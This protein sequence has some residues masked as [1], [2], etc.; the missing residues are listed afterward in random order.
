MVERVAYFKTNRELSDSLGQYGR[1]D[2]DFK[3]G[4]FYKFFTDGQGTH[5]YDRNGKEVAVFEYSVEINEGNVVSMLD[6]LLAFSFAKLYF[7]EGMKGISGVGL[8]D[9]D[10]PEEEL[11]KVISPYREFIELEDVKEFKEKS[12]LG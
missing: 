1:F 9:F 12:G 3:L 2:R 11:G 4:D 7:E 6:I 5:V 8:V 10:A